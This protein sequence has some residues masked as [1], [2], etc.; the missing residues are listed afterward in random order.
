DG[1][2][3][4]PVPP[5]VGGEGRGAALRR[6][7]PL[8]AGP[9]VLPRLDPG[10]LPGWRPLG[11]PGRGPRHQDLPHLRDLIQPETGSGRLPKRARTL[12]PPSVEPPDLA[13]LA[14]VAAEYGVEILGPPP[15]PRVLKP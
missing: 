8:P 13:R 10:R 9:A 14:A 12:P 7:A 6:P 3:V 4:V 5:D 2:A 1:L 11:H 15:A